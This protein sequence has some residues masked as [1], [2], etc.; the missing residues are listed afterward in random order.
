MIFAEVRHSEHYNNAHYVIVQLLREHFHDLTF[1]LQSDSYVKIVVDGFEVRIDTFSSML[2]WVKAERH[3]ALVDQIISI[4]ATVFEV[5]QFEFPLLEGPPDEEVFEAT[6]WVEGKIFSAAKRDAL[7]RLFLSQGWKV[8]VTIYE[9]W[10]QS[11]CFAFEES[12]P[13]E[14]SGFCATIDDA[15]RICRRFSDV[16]ASEK[17]KHYFELAQGCEVID[18]IEYS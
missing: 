5:H 18:R 2:H 12:S 9:V 17:L 16:L 11:F 6:V 15:L 3:E 1:G 4:L 8:D 10:S 14:I 7:A 13:T